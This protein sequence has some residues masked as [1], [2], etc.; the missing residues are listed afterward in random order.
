M[1]VTKHQMIRY[2]V[3]DKCLSN[4]GRKYSFNDIR[5]EVINVLNEKDP[6]TKGISIQSLRYD[7]NFME[8]KEGWNAPITRIREGR[9]IFYRYSEKFSIHEHPLNE[10]ERI[11]ME[12]LIHALRQFEGRPEF[13]F[14]KEL[15]PIF[16]DKF[17]ATRNAKPIIGYESNIDYSYTGAYWIPNLFN[18]ISNKRCLKIKYRNFQGVEF[19]DICHPYYLKQFNNRWF[20]FGGRNDRIKNMDDKNLNPIW[21]YALDR[22]VEISELNEPYIVSN[23]DWEDYFSDIIGVTNINDEKLQEVQL[24]F[25]SARAGHVMT[26]PLHPSQKDTELEDGKILVRIIVKLN[27]ELESTIL[28]F[29]RDV[30]VLKP[31]RL[32]KSIQGHLRD[33]V[34]EYDIE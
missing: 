1:P 14:L 4:W 21:N 29:G 18:A 12:S 20:L 26:K 8:S 25:S 7:F 16:A 11:Q 31:D 5:D 23:M 3:I 6:N 33:A 9:E 19:T 30:K 32:V 10:S 2:S 24:E 27:K 28:S 22:I 13:E 34:S 15:G 17:G